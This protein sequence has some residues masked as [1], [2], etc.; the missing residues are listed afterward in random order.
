M[1]LALVEVMKFPFH[2]FFWAH[3]LTKWKIMS[4]PLF[5]VEQVVQNNKHDEVYM[6]YGIRGIT[7]KVGSIYNRR[8][9][10]LAF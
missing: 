8:E 4:H 9:Y 6:V 3:G 1:W 7:W 10:L 5:E 2:L